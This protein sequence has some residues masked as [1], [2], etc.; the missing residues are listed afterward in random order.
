V[1]EP[2]LEAGEGCLSNCQRTVQ[3][4]RALL[5][6]AF[7]KLKEQLE[8]FYGNMERQYKEAGSPYGDNRDG[9]FKWWGKKIKDNSFVEA[10]ISFDSRGLVIRLKEKKGKKPK[11]LL[12][13]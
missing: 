11:P 3:N 10:E 4:I 2:L 1:N 9:V 12:I 5:Q 7:M 13:W 6:P 8:L